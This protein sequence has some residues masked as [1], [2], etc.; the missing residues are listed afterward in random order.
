MKFPQFTYFVSFQYVQLCLFCLCQSWLFS[1]AEY[2]SESERNWIRQHPQIDYGYEPNWPP[3]EIY[4][5]NQYTG[6]IGDYVEILAAE[7]GIQ[8]NPIPDISWEKSLD[9]LESGTIHFVPSCAFTPQ[10]EQFLEFTSPI[11]TEPII[12]ATNKNEAF[13]GN[14]TFLNHKS[15]ALPKNYYTIELIK[16]AYPNIRIVE[17][18]HIEDCLKAVST[19][20]V[21]AFVGSLGVVSYY[22]NHK[23]FTNIKI[24]A[25][26]NFPDARI[27]MA[28]SKDWIELR[29]IA[30]KVIDRIPIKKHNEIRQK[31]ISVRY[32]HGVSVDQLNLYIL[33][34]VFTILTVVLLFYIWNRSLKKEIKKRERVEH[35]LS[36][37]IIEIQK[38]SDERKVLLQEIHHRVKNN[39]QNVSSMIKLQ[40]ASSE[41]LGIPFDVNKTIDRINAISLIHEMIYKSE[42]LNIENIEPYLLRLIHE[43]IQ[44]HADDKK[45]Q[46][47]V[48]IQKT[49]INLKTFVPIAIIVNELVINSIK[50]GFKFR[51]EGC[52]SLSIKTSDD[53]LILKYADDGEWKNQAQPAGFGTSLIEIF[54]EQLDGNYTLETDHGTHYLFHLNIK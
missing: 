53:H 42:S 38:Q 31:W 43:I 34:G 52:I 15:I 24:A 9:G 11:I 25:P 29:N 19:G 47:E 18:N 35:K 2:F 49:H 50:H 1:Q 7:T 14:L 3:Y 30:Q 8:F 6:V 12:I 10:R 37:S 33:I 22:I 5:N 4:E 32:E 44:L 16:K 27:G 54:T 26:T 46:L 20:E 48:A 39:L 23:G 41:E 45:I 28:T 51:E 17:K 40:A 13:I 36:A 21:S